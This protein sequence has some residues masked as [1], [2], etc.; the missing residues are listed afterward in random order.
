[1][2][3]K[4]GYHELYHL[5]KTTVQ[6]FTPDVHMSYILSLCSYQSHPKKAVRKYVS[7]TLKCTVDCLL[8]N[9]KIN[10]NEHRN[11]LAKI[12]LY[13]NHS[14]NKGIYNE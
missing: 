6:E 5:N 1:M 3:Y 2:E 12:D 10:I 13:V 8:L 11:Y 4:S 9:N 7:H 14:N